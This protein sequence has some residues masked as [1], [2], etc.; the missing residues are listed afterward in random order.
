MKRTLPYIAPL[1]FRSSIFSVSMPDPTITLRP[2]RSTDESFLLRLFRS[3][4]DDIDHA[5]G[6]SE[7]EKKTFIRQQ[8]EAQRRS[9]RHKYPDSS[10]ELILVDDERAGRIW[11]A[12]LKD[13]I[14]LVDIMVLPAFQN[15]GVGS[16]LVQTLKEYARAL[17]RPLR[18]MVHTTNQDALRFYRRLGFSKQPSPVPTHHAMVWRPEQ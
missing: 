6:I 12:H 11:V 14:R 10:P 4:R 16:H 17:Q 3:F 18:H 7:A 13:Q 1:R 2:V 9:Y 15:Q 8:F 5:V